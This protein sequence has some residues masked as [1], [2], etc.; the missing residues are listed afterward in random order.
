MKYQICVGPSAPGPSVPAAAAAD[1]ATPHVLM[2]EQPDMPPAAAD[3]VPITPTSVPDT[4]A[5]QHQ[6]SVADLVR[7]AP[8]AWH[9]STGEQPLLFAYHVPKHPPPA[10]AWAAFSFTHLTPP[11]DFTLR[12]AG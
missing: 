12:R 4:G 8:P 11:N 2:P 1:A 10:I 6:A 7:G 3:D 9:A 5:T